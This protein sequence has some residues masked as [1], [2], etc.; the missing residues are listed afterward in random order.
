MR[1]QYRPVDQPIPLRGE[2]IRYD[3]RLAGE[4][5]ARVPTDKSFSAGADERREHDEVV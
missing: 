4:Q 2:F 1:N 5:V 3:D